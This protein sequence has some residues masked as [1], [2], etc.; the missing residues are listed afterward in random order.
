MNVT[1]SM[2]E[3]VILAMLYYYYVQSL[4][5]QYWGIIQAVTTRFLN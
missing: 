4:H 5:K 1:S 2:N 3:A